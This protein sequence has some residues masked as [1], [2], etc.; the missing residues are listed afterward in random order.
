MHS[1]EEH[2]ERYVERLV[3]DAAIS[4]ALVKRAFSRVKR[5][6][7]VDHWYRLG[8]GEGSQPVWSLIEFDR[9]RPTTDDLAEIYSN[10]S[11]VTVVDGPMPTSST[12]QPT[13]VAHMLE[14]L[15]LEPGM[16]VLEI[17]TGTGY[18]AALLA[19]IVGETGSVTSVDLQPDVAAT[20][21][22]SLHGEG[23]AGVRVE[24][25]DGMRGAPE[26]AP[27]DRIIAT[28]GCS[29]V[30]PA[31][32]Q[33]LAENG[34]IVLPLRHGAGDFL[35]RVIRDPE[36]P[37]EGIGIV[38]GLSFFMSIQ[39]AWATP[40][41]WQSYGI[42]GLPSEP[43]V[44]L[45]LPA[46]LA[47]GQRVDAPPLQD[48]I[49]QAFHFFLSLTSREHWFTLRGYGLADP[50]AGATLLVTRDA[51][52]GYAATKSARR[53]LDRLIE[54]LHEL[55]DHWKAL[56]APTPADYACRFVPKPRFSV[57]PAGDEPRWLVERLEHWEIVRLRTGLTDR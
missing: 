13:V 26:R 19:E 25:R 38:G 45:P 32:L 18:N 24:V 44:T 28:V 54:R 34:L 53:G 10:Q 55:L 40:N 12:S 9:D 36:S 15:E 16:N 52:E 7:F 41:P 20:A 46:P 4:S 35:M 39:G 31:W 47:S 51:L 33:Q 17:G 3:E 14:L 1:V 56:G 5:H 57:L 8:S 2:I 21:A 42:V 29:D 30:A 49:H 50:G 23:Y 11:L 43:T 27:F 48:P 6:R 22:M 37:Q